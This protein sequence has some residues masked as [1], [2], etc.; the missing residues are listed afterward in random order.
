M[1][2]Y[3]KANALARVAVDHAIK[4]IV[5][6]LER[7]TERSCHF[8][9]ICVL[10]AD[11]GKSEAIVTTTMGKEDLIACFRELLDQPPFRA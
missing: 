1:M 4:L 9:A 6:E 2:E 8:T 11:S 7:R 5:E 3:Q 10:Q